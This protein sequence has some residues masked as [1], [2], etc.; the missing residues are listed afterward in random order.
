MKAILEGTNLEIGVPIF[1]CVVLF[2]FEQKVQRQ[3]VENC[4]I[5]NYCI[6]LLSSLLVR[7]M[8]CLIGPADSVC[9]G[10]TCT[11]IHLYCI[12]IPAVSSLRGNLRWVSEEECPLSW[13]K[14]FVMSVSDLLF[15]CNI[16]I[17]FSLINFSFFF[18]NRF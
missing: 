12:V 8:I 14:Y 5:R 10:V 6:F 9:A 7:Y 1:L 15:C 3:I 11:E 17:I 16:I 2:D 13:T 18:K 4:E